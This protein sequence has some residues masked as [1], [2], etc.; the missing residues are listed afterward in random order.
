VDRLR[1]LI[2]SL[3]ADGL[4]PIADSGDNEQDALQTQ[5]EELE[6]QRRKILQQL[7]NLDEQL[8]LHEQTETAF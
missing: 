6:Q 7:A 8:R 2:I 3:Q 1:S 5:L 4:R